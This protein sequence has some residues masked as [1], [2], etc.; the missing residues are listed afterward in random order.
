MC[1]RKRERGR[2]GDSR[3]PSPDEGDIDLASISDPRLRRL[4]A[5]RLREREEVKVPLVPT[6]RTDTVKPEKD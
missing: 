2:R 6:Y 3:S 1:A 4:L 5:A